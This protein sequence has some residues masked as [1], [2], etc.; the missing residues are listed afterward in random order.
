MGGTQVL[1]TE[2]DAVLDHVRFLVNSTRNERE[3]NV[4]LVGGAVGTGKTAVLTRFAEIARSR[5]AVVLTAVAFPAGPEVS[6]GV[7]DQLVGGLVPQP[8]RPGSAD[9]L[10]RYVSAAAPRFNARVLHRAS[11]VLTEVAQESHL[12]V[13]VDDIQHMDAE[14]VQFMLHFIRASAGLPVTFAFTETA[15]VPGTGTELHD[16]L[17]RHQRVRRFTLRPLSADGV[18]DVL[19]EDVGRSAT[20]L[21]E[22]AVR[23]TGGNPLLLFALITDLRDRG[24]DGGDPGGTGGAAGAVPR[25]VVP[26][27]NFQRAYRSCLR[28][29]GELA[30]KVVTALAVLGDTATALLAARLTRT[31]I[32][33]VE[34]VADWLGQAGLLSWLRFRHPA[35]RAAVLA[36]TDRDEL[37]GLHRAAARLLFETGAPTREVAGHLLVCG[38]TDEPFAG[39]VLADAAEQ[40]LLAGQAEDAT[41]YLYL[42]H[43]QPADQMEEAEAALALSAVEWRVNPIGAVRR[44]HGLAELVIEGQLTD[45]RAVAVAENLL[46]HGDVAEAEQAFTALH[47]RADT[48]DA[49]TRSAFAEA[50]SMMSAGFPAVHQRLRARLPDLEVDAEQPPVGLTASSCPLLTFGRVRWVRDEEA[51]DAAE[52]LLAATPVNEGTLPRLTAAVVTLVAAE[53]TD[54][55]VSW[56]EHV[57]REIEGRHAPAWQAVLD[58]MRGIV[59]LQSGDYAEAEAH[60]RAALSGVPARVWGAGIGIPLATALFAATAQGRHAD[61]RALVGQPVPASMFESVYGL[62][63]LTACGEYHLAARQYRSA[64]ERFTQ[65]GEL[66][67]A[68]EIATP[69]LVSWRFGAARAW[70]GLGDQGEARRLLEE[71]LR[72]LG[73][74]PSRGRGLSLRLLA[75]IHQA[76]RRQALLEQAVDV[77]SRVDARLELTDALTDLGTFFARRG[78]AKRAVAVTRRIVEL[79]REWRA[80]APVKRAPRRWTG[81]TAPAEGQARLTSLTEA[82]RRV[83]A[84]AADG[85]SNKEIAEALSITVSTVEQHLTR[86]YRKL[87]IRRRRELPRQL[88]VAGQEQTGRL[89]G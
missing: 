46:W 81:G 31:D 32:A 55:A 85:W 14:A 39:R 27:E 58:G 70:L 2:R 64:L 17:A 41:A 43:R 19:A 62:V 5:G 65:C 72:L 77:L 18:Q 75:S 20:A 86:S 66:I 12:V 47:E 28:A 35:A 26:G 84:M 48:F 71:D 11:R 83:S 36:G 6:S 23:I 87:S 45:H 7:V 29:G 82:E 42:V 4:V 73:D 53:R 76:G 1:L 69:G 9:E 16:Y 33:T 8:R 68:W 60:A 21:T 51:A 80:K 54:Q 89:V 59:A 67:A 3:A 40:A 34:A 78:D 13:C 24:D 52:A 61:A 79:T 37:I 30:R 63:Y 50:V 56:S 38:V 74:S 49:A 88:L 15:G 57:M 22:Q 10:T 25:R 44:L